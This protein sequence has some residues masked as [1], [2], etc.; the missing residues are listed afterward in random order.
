MPNP[1]IRLCRVCVLLLVSGLATSLSFAQENRI[2]AL[3]ELVAGQNIYLNVGQEAGINETDSLMAYRDGQ[4]L[5]MLRIVG[6]TATRTVATF[7]G[8]PF[9]VT[10]GDALSIEILSGVQVEQPV[11][12]TLPD[13]MA[14]EPAR[15]SVFEGGRTGV[16]LPPVEEGIRVTGRLSLSLDLHSSE[17]NGLISNFSRDRIYRIP[18]VNLRASVEE[19]PGNLR[20]N[21]NTRYANRYNDNTRLGISPLNALRV[22]QLNVEYDTPDTPFEARLGRFF[23]P[24]ETF[25][26]YWDGLGLSYMPDTGFGAGVLG[27]F[28]PTRA[29]EDFVTDFPKYSAFGSYSFRSNDGA[30][31]YNANVSFHQVFPDASELSTHTFLGFTHTL[32]TKQF[33]LRNLVQVDQDPF[34]DSWKISRLQV[35]G[36]VPINQSLSLRARYLARRPY[37]LL[38]TNDVFGYKRE[39]VSG[40]FSVRAFTGI[41]SADVA[42][43][44]SDIIERNLTYTGFAS[45]PQTNILDLGVST[46]VHYWRR[47]DGADVLYIAP[48]IS[49][50]FGRTLAQLQ[51][52]FQQSNF[53]VIETSN[54]TMEGV[55]NFPIG[56]RIRTSIRLQSRWGDFNNMFRVYTTLWT[57]I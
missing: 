42:L 53:D 37:N 12:E 52:N 32:N 20:F 41:F 55:L 36:I 4:Q 50:Y 3:V 28:Q 26:G 24:A 47:D 17:T 39:R 22:Y 7:A 21:I 54:H 23:N 56:N 11:A 14:T 57:R 43:N 38:L 1:L 8:T 29:N 33:R 31:R 45:I 44:T 15:Q 30:T 9:P 46:S 6:V 35:Y 16:Q 48:A 34:S 13:T 18:V 2:D 10:R 19:L 40:G 27:G 51:Y 49:R 5:G 25:S